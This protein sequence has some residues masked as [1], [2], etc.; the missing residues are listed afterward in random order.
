MVDG[1]YLEDSNAV[2][3]YK[4]VGL[5]HD[6]FI[7]LQ[8]VSDLEMQ[9][10]MIDDINES[11]AIGKYFIMRLNDNVKSHGYDKEINAKMFF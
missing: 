2:I 10:N 9:V 11:L 5:T 1:Y 3:L 8:S 7:V 4:L 6:G